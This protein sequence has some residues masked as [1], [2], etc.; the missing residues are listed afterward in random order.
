MSRKTGLLIF[1]FIAVLLRLVP[2]PPNFAPITALAIFSGYN[3]S[4]KAAGILIPLLAL[5]L[6]DLYLGF[7]TI[8]PWVYGGFALISLF[9]SFQKKISVYTTLTGTLLFFIVSNFGVWLLGY[10]KTLEGLVLC[11][12]M[13]IPFAINSLL[14]DLFYTGLLNYSF[15]YTE[16]KWLTT[17]S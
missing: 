8:T 7:S 13:A 15:K 3:Y 5:I 17:I 10:P 4:N 16:K 14:G 1:V 9:S 2:H 12:T 6:S 11:Y